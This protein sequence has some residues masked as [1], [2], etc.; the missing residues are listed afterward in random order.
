MT[1]P[2][3]FTFN[4][5][6][7]NFHFHFNIPGRARNIRNKRVILHFRV[8]QLEIKNM[9]DHKK[10]NLRMFV[11]WQLLYT[12]RFAYFLNQHHCNRCFRSILFSSYL[13]ILG[14]ISKKKAWNILK[15]LHLKNS[16]TRR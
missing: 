10:R 15:V 1:T 12:F 2:F 9:Y 13:H 4:L 3:I 6:S 8:Q 14:G 7:N 16:L 5:L 11:I